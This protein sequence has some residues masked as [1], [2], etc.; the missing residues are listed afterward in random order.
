MAGVGDV[1]GDGAERN[2]GAMAAASARQPVPACP[3][4]RGTKRKMKRRVSEG[5]CKSER[6]NSAGGHQPYEDGR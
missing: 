4:P 5:K 2:D 3:I 1:E 6:K